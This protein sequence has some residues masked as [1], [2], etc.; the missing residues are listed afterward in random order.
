MGFKVQL[1]HRTNNVGQQD[2]LWKNQKL[3]RLVCQFLA[4]KQ[5]GDF[6]N[7]GKA[8]WERVLFDLIFS[9]PIVRGISFSGC[10]NSDVK[11]G[12]VWVT[13]GGQK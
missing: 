7:L 8:S 13:M 9:K 11:D 10:H 5:R 4:L 3:S 1:T 6:T 2:I 12:R